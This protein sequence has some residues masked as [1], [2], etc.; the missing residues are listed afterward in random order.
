MKSFRC[1]GLESVPAQH[2]LKPVE[3]YLEVVVNL[4][5]RRELVEP[6]KDL[7]VLLSGGAERLFLGLGQEIIFIGSHQKRWY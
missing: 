1:R 4:I 7:L 3:K 5:D 2:R 6:V